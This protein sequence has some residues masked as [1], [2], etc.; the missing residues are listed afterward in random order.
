MKRLTAWLSLTALL[1]ALGPAQA[2][3]PQGRGDAR[4]RRDAS[5]GGLRED[6]RRE[7]GR[8]DEQGNR[9]QPRLSPEER[10]ELRQQIHEAGHDVYQKPKR[11]SP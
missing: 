7:E 2:E 1:L 4:S 11:P 10:R 9:Q 3:P 8:W 6:V 5:A